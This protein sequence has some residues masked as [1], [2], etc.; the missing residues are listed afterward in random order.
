SN[1]IH[2]YKYANVVD[3][4]ANEN[5]SQ[6]KEATIKN[7][8]EKQHTVRAKYFIIACCSVQN[9]RILLSSHKQAP[10]GLG[11]DHDHVGR[12]FMEHLEI[13]TSSLWLADPADVKLYMMDFGVTKARAE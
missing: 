6:I 8:A 12:Y 5:V 2:M 1:N 10:K 11:N 13:K 3:V 7:Y 4:T 9:A